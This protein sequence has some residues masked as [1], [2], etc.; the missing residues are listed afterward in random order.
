AAGY[1]RLAHLEYLPLPGGDAGVKYPLR[2]AYAYLRSLLSEQEW[3]AETADLWKGWLKKQEIAM[4]EQQLA[5]RYRVFSTSSAGRLFDAVSAVL[6]ICTQVTYEGQA[7]IELE[8]V[9]WTWLKD[10][11]IGQL[12]QLGLQPY[13][14][15]WL[16]GPVGTPLQVTV[17]KLFLGILQDRRAGLENGWIALRFHL[18]IAAIILQTV[19]RLDVGDHSVVINGG[20]FQNKLLTEILL[21]QCAKR[22][23]RVLRTKNLPPGDG[24]IAYGQV[25]VANA[26]K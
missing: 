21:T 20:V 25:M 1:Q 7:A 22:Q 26:W 5:H 13:A 19:L 8:S 16:E 3:A 6:G 15:E 18:S 4:L 23:L 14:F 10:G 24:G 17:K 9:A 2:I 12:E 11:D